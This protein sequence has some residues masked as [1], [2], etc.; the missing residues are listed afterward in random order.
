MYVT[1]F[2]TKFVTFTNQL[3][4]LTFVA[5][6]MS[7]SD[8]SSTHSI[9]EEF[10]QLAEVLGQL[11]EEIKEEYEA[12]GGQLFF[13]IVPTSD[14]VHL[15]FLAKTFPEDDGYFGDEEIEN[16]TDLAELAG[17]LEA[18]LESEEV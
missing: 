9:P 11:M 2:T 15:C 4:L 16:L 7:F 5:K 18:Y 8:S 6:K 12:E 1:I 14:C 13:Q 3:Q 10:S 17:R